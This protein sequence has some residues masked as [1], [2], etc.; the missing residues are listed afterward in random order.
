[1]RKKI[2]RSMVLVITVTMLIS[3]LLLTVVVYHQ[4]VSIIEDEIRQEADYICK[5][6]EISGEE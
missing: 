5:A 4:S 6:L 2:Q 3:Y 1:M